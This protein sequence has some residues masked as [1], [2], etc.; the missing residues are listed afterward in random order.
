MV[1]RPDICI[2]V[3]LASS[4]LFG[5]IFVAMIPLLFPTLSKGRIKLI[6]YS[7]LA[8]TALLFF[9]A[10]YIALG[11]EQIQM[12]R[13]KKMLALIFLVL[14]AIGFGVSA[15]VFLS[16]SS[17][18]IDPDNVSSKPGSDKTREPDLKINGVAI[19]G[20]PTGVSMPKGSTLD[21]T[22]SKISRGPGQTD[23]TGIEI[24][25]GSGYNGPAGIRYNVPP[26]D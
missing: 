20:F 10:V 18:S 25:D 1:M 4:A 7:S 9:A 22:D 21:A 3:L 5:G 6:S 11:A 15:Y 16:P 26:K 23:G 12:E 17:P 13:S 2:A 24:R 8:L 14:C 19:E